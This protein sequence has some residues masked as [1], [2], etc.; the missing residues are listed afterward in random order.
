MK[1]CIIYFSGTGNTE[2]V[3]RAINKN[4]QKQDCI[5]EVVA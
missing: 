2:Y 1:G 4:L 3:A 5:K